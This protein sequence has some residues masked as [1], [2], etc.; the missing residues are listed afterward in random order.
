MTLIHDAQAQ[1]V[2]SEDDDTRRVA[3]NGYIVHQPVALLC[4]DLMRN[5]TKP[6]NLSTIYELDSQDDPS[7][8]EDPYLLRRPFLRRQVTLTTGH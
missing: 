3:G 1:I 5:G 2:M 4:T 7:I 8:A 6:I